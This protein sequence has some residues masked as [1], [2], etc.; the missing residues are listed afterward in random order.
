[1]TPSIWA[2]SLGETAT[3]VSDPYADGAVCA[4]MSVTVDG[5]YSTVQRLPRT[6]DKDIPTELAWFARVEAW[7]RRK[8]EHEGW[9]VDEAEVEKRRKEIVERPA[10]PG[11][12]LSSFRAKRGRRGLELARAGE[13]FAHAQ[14]G[15]VLFSTPNFDVEIHVDVDGRDDRKR[16]VVSELSIGARPDGPPLTV[17]AVHAM[18]LGELMHEAVGMLT[19]D[20]TSATGLAPLR[21]QRLA[22]ELL[23]AERTGTRRKRDDRTGAVDPHL[24]HVAAVYS[25]APSGGRT[26][27]VAQALGCSKSAAAKRIMAARK[28]GELPRVER[29]DGYWNRRPKVE[30]R[31]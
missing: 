29:R 2:A 14:P 1:M 30:P 24:K 9:T 7:V 20:L 25:N 28:A 10:R 31:R 12:T 18:K 6:W 3:R 5:Y 17:R 15:R 21:D 4:C 22:A 8:A 23:L 13:P 26:A 19:V 16:M 27:A 11:G